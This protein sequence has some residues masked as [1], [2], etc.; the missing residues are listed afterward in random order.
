LVTAVTGAAFAHSKGC[1]VFNG[2]GEEKPET[3]PIV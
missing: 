1:C 2:L 3:I